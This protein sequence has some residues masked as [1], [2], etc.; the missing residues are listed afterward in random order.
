MIR[1]LYILLSVL[2]FDC[3]AQ[4]NDSL[5]RLK[6]LYESELTE[7]NFEELKH[8]LQNVTD[9]DLE[10]ESDSLKYIY[11]YCNAIYLDV[12]GGNQDKEL[13][14]LEKS[15]DLRR[16]KLGI[17][18]Y[19]YLELMLAYGIL[20]EEISQDDA[21]IVYEKLLVDGIYAFL[22]DKVNTMRSYGMAMN[23]LARLYEKKGYEKQLID[24]YRWSFDLLKSNYVKGDATSYYSLYMLSAYFYGKG[25][26]MEAV[27][28]MNK[29]LSYIEQ[30]EG[31][32]CAAYIQAL[33]Y[34]AGCFVACGDWIK[35][36]DCYV[37]SKHL[38]MELNGSVLE[39]TLQYIDTLENLIE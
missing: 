38:Q 36:R 37:Q 23:G 1:I 19:E 12:V 2:C 28:E 7:N 15:I 33:N 5:S 3:V 39:E 14:C 35:A 13:E 11:Y 22:L 24:L 16:A 30:N 10:N 8:T 17:H 20:L 4:H 34:K 18:H 21:I 29:V 6:K 26:Y 32:V 9:S 25:R 31:K 27:E